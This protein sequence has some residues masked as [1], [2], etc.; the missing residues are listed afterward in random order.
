MHAMQ[1]GSTLGNHALIRNRKQLL[2]I[3]QS[4]LNLKSLTHV[5]N[6]HILILFS[7]F[8]KNST[9]LYLRKSEIDMRLL[10]LID[11]NVV[12]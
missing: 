10:E 12:D 9:S 5:N 8:N 1:L 2:H 6:T 7:T 4:C 3:Q 11:K